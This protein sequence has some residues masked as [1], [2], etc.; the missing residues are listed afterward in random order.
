MTAGQQ[1]TRSKNMINFYTKQL[2]DRA[3]IIERSDSIEDAE[4]HVASIEQELRM[5]QEIVASLTTETN[6]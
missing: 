5:H 6:N 1:L 2:A 3:G 4:Y